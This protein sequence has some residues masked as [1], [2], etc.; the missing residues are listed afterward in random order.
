MTKRRLFPLLLLWVASLPCAVQAKQFAIVADKA[1]ANSNLTT[2][3]LVKI[4]NA[5]SRSW[6]DGKPITVVMRDP[7]SADMQLVLRKLFNM[8]P[9]QAH[10]FIQ[11]HRDA[12]MVA[13]SDDAVLRFVSTSRGAIGVVDLYSLTQDVNVLKI[14]GKLPV[15]QGY[16]LR[17]N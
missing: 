10:A 8:T 14:D 6:P 17:G 5:H 2:S 12:I 11:A 16:L 7:S 15:E 13:D 3:E 4:F 1:N 9:E